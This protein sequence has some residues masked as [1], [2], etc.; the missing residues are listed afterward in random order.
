MES[1]STGLVSFP[2]GDNSSDT[3]ISGRHWNL[4]TLQTFGYNLYSN[5]MLSNNSRCYLFFEPWNSLTILSDN[6]TFHNS[7]SCFSPVLPL[8]MRS[9]ISLGFA[10]LFSTAL[11]L[12]VANLAKHG[13]ELIKPRENRFGVFR[14]RFQWYW[15]IVVAAFGLVCSITTI[16]V[17][18]Y[19]LPETPFVIMSV[20]YFLVLLS[21]L[22]FVWESVWHWGSWL[23]RKAIEE[24]PWSWNQ[25]DMRRKVEMWIPLFFYLLIAAVGPQYLPHLWLS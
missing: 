18:R 23:E 10:A 4:T 3:L 15:M 12:A 20:F 21:T 16:D 19:Y 5:H 24:D 9:K 25:E 7:A 22:A 6:G 14:R 17:D 2:R 11:V 13:K 1:L 8:R